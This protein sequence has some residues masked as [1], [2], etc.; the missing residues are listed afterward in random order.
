M[1]SGY[2]SI[3]N[4]LDLHLEQIDVREQCDTLNHRNAFKDNV[5]STVK[6][7]ISLFC[8]HKMVL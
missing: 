5:K 7:F 3:R 6:A 1:G 8:Y 2:G 4:E